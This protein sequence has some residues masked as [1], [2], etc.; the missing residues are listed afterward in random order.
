MLDESGKKRS[1]CITGSALTYRKSHGKINICHFHIKLAFS[2]FQSTFSYTL[3][4]TTRNNTDVQLVANASC[5]K[6]LQENLQ[7]YGRKKL[8]EAA[9]RRSSLKKS[10]RDLRITLLL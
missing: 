9:R 8:L 4:T 3:Y 10:R 2:K 1:R 6:A 7:L 5:G